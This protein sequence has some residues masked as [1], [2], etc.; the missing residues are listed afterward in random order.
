MFNRSLVRASYGLKTFPQAIG[1]CGRFQRRPYSMAADSS[2]STLPLAGYRVLDM[3]RVLAG[4]Y[5]TQILGDLGAEVIKIEHP[6]RGDDTR[7]WGPPYASYTSGSAQDG[8][9]EAAYF[10]AVNRNKKSLGLSF[11][12]PEGVEILH[13]L[14]AE[15][16]ILVENYLPGSLKKYGM[17][18]DT[19]HKINPRLV[20][21]SITGYGQ[22][23][24]YASRAGYDVMVE[25]EFGLMH[26]TGARDGP[27]VKVGVAVTDLTTGLYTS[28]SIMAALLARGKTGRGQH[29]DVALSDCQTATLANIASSCLISGKKDTGRWGT[30]HPSIVPYKSFKTKDGDILLGGGNDRL[31]GILCDGIGRPEWKTDPKYAINAQR[32]AN[33]DELEDKIEAL[34]VGK[35]TKE[36]LDVFEG[37]GMPYAAVN[38]VQGTLNHE[39]TQARNMVVEMEHSECGPIKM[40]NTPV[41]YSESRPSIRTPPPTLGQHTD[42]V[43]GGI[44]GLK[45]SEIEG[46]KAKGTVR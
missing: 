24:P 42:E 32:V 45:P 14:A 10:L 36:W 44:L 46:L 8:P 35:T 16:D 2:S 23:G 31:F 21:A 7:A 13:K 3:T 5:C 28:N 29:I 37:K 27:P 41:K 4:P 9:G 6:V 22:T 25:A 15:C 33:R 17:D 34:T 26:I 30:A 20:Y 40:V 43:L 38:D 39:H 12:H 1:R 19:L 11:Q 18:F